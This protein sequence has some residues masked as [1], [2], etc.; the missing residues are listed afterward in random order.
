[1]ALA[2]ESMMK[3]SAV[4]NRVCEVFKK[5]KYVNMLSDNDKLSDNIMLSDNML[6]DNIML[7]DN[8]LSD[9]IILSYNI[10]L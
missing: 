1:M 10:M 6:S 2:H 5:I 4:E 3:K 8:M 9:N 7:S